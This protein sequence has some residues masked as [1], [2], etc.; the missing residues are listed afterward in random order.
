MIRAAPPAL[1]RARRLLDPALRERVGLL[2]PGVRRVVAYHLGYTDADGR[3]AEGDGGKAV[4]PALAFLSA[5][6]VGAPAEVALPGAVAVELVHNFSLLHDDVMDHDLE[7]RHRPTA[8]ALFGMGQAIVTG[9]ALMIEAITTLL[10]PPT[11]ERTRATAALTS[12]TAR[13]I[14]GQAQDLSF[15]SRLDVSTE[16]CVAM[17]AN[18]TGA[19]LSCA[20]SIGA[21]LAGADEGAVAALAA[22]GLHLGLAF[23]AI[24]D[25]LGIWGQPEATG[26]PVAGDLREHKKTLPVVIALSST[27]PDR[28]RLETL[29][30]NGALTDETVAMAADLVDRCGGRDECLREAER[31]TDLAL[32][33]LD[34]APFDAAA[35]GQLA[36]VGA[37]VTA[38]DF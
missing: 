9:D 19:L 21:I 3:P 2:P 17:C 23:Q 12:A 20:A 37:F 24:D 25:L 8:W 6:A 38:R 29:L 1:L 35:R 27:G 28:D 32:R 26:K 7:R 15:A 22:F 10:D 18:K 31:Q 4:R 30:S 33:A 34:Q 16:E 11:P 13:M 14:A 36:E 5:E